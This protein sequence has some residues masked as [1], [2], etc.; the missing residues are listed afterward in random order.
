[1]PWPV[2]QMR[3]W[4]E[5]DQMT[6]QDI[7]DKLSSDEWQDYWRKHLGR[8]YR[9]D[10]K[11]V[12]KVAKSKGFAMR[13]TGATGGRNGSWKGGRTVDKCGYVL[14]KRPEHPYANVHGYV[15][16]H[17][18]I[19]EQKLGRF[20]LPT[21]VVH[22]VDDDPSNN[23]PDNLVVYSTNAEHLAETLIGKVPKWTP[24]GWAGM[25][26]PRGPRPFATRRRR[27]KSDA[28]ESP[29]ASRRSRKKSGK[30]RTLP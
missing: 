5:R 3:E 1:M 12:N 24:E 11:V 25:R 19:A 10:Q 13:K 28:Q 27:P 9:P 8:E 7:A 30:D 16:E 26:A 2:D 4:Y 17:R 22:H 6:L 18:L 20:L 29:A 14:V 15:R 23:S 21:E